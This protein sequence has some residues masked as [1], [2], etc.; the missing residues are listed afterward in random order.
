MK[1]AAEATE[2]EEGNGQ[3]NKGGQWQGYGPGHFHGH[4]YGH[5]E[6]NKVEDLFYQAAK[7]MKVHDQEEEKS[8]SHY[9]EKKIVNGYYEERQRLL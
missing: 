1:A 3:R 9:Y 4:D 6:T 8:R 2:R 7:K 5:A